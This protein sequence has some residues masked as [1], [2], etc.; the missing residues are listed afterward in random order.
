MNTTQSFI[1]QFLRTRF[2]ICVLLFL[3]L[4]ASALLEIYPVKYMS[5]IIDHIGLGSEYGYIIMSV[6]M[7]YGLRV[8]GALMNYC[9]SYMSVYL[10]TMLGAELRDMIFDRIRKSDL[11]QIAAQTSAG[12]LTRFVNDVQDI[13]NLIIGPATF[14]GKHL[15]V[16]IWACIFLYR[17]DY[18][19]LLSCIALG[20]LMLF[21]GHWAAKK[22]K[23][24]WKNQKQHTD[25]LASTIIESIAGARDILLTKTWDRQAA[26]FSASNANLTA[27]QIRG[28][29]VK[30]AVDSTIDAL[31]PLATVICLL[32]GGHRVIEGY[33]TLGH[34][35]SF[36]WYVQWVIHPISQLA[37]YKSEMQKSLASVERISELS[38][39]F[40]GESPINCKDF[41]I[42]DSVSLENISFTYPGS[43]MGVRDISITFPAGSTVAIVGPTGCGKS[44][45]LKLVTGLIKPDQ[46]RIHVDGQRV[47]SKD[48]LGNSS[49]AASCHNPYMFTDTLKN[50][51]ILERESAD[52]DLLSKVLQ[53]SQCNEFINS[54]SCDLNDVL[55]EGG[56]NLSTGQQ[57]RIGVARALYARPSLLVL[58]EATS[59]VDY[60]TEEKIIRA[61]KDMDDKLT[62]LMVS[63]RMSTVRLADR[64]CVMEKGRVVGYGSHE[65]LIQSVELYKKLTARD[66]KL[67]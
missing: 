30:S 1:L 4:I 64:I 34:M 67:G 46:G 7:W 26:S 37:V 40:Y 35:V 60:R 39:W 18:V 62:I 33:I 11:L 56:S 55:L 27:Y 29:R 38:R 53:I 20:I 3:S 49:V 66:S 13:G 24:I 54:K 58:D 12:T 10:S 6:V 45:L 8:L 22:N 59:G 32:V 52:R 57:Q 28:G 36:M 23:V 16:F 50:N 2:S 9:S 51:I 31:W 48:L 5:Q 44:T 17:I 41:K 47:D 61:L 65:E 25:Y 21:V 43:D 14:V 15:F 42:L 63:H 19:L